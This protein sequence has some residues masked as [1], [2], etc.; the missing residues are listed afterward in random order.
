M[1]CLPLVLD[2]SDDIALQTTC[3]A[4]DGDTT[5]TGHVKKSQPTGDTCRAFPTAFPGQRVT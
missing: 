3:F 4:D 2:P 5:M 1:H